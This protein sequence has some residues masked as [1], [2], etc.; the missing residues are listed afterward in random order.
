MPCT[1]FVADGAPS[2]WENVDLDA[3]KAAGIAIQT[4]SR[5]AYG[6]GLNARQVGPLDQ[7]IDRSK[8]RCELTGILFSSRIVGVRR[9]FIP[10]V[11]RIEPREPYTFQ[12]CRLVCWIVNMARGDWG[13]EVFWEMVRSAYEH[14]ARLSES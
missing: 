10:S 5:K 6:Q 14:R 11:D 4:A 12:N 13:D 7:L 1:K 3:A 2:G 9:P 8:G